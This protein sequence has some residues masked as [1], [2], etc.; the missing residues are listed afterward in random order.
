[1]FQYGF[2]C[3]EIKKCG[4]GEAVGLSPEQVER[5]DLLLSVQSESKRSFHCSAISNVTDIDASS[6][7]PQ[8]Y[9]FFPAMKAF[10]SPEWEQLFHG[11]SAGP[12]AAPS[13]QP[14]S[15][16]PG[17]PAAFSNLGTPAL[18]LNPNTAAMEGISYIDTGQMQ[19]LQPWHLDDTQWWQLQDPE[20]DPAAVATIL[21]LGDK[22][23]AG[24]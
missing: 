14:A 22:D 3:A 20:M 13:K 8:R 10:E 9:P 23:I 5:Y 4:F 1:M 11:T 2:L 19:M 17:Q 18:D 12:S 21:G 24:D 6:W 15:A 7:L 16:A